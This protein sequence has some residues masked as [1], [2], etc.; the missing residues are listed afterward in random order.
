MRTQSSTERSKTIV[1]ATGFETGAGANAASVAVLD[2]D[3][4]E[5]RLEAGYNMIE[6]AGRG[7][8]AVQ[9]ALR[10]AGGQG[11]ITG[12]VDAIFKRDELSQRWLG[13]Y[14]VLGPDSRI[15]ALESFLSGE[16]YWIYATEPVTWRVPKADEEG[17]G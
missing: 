5:I 13:Y 6:W 2:N 17:D 10:G 3:S 7:G 1:E 4:V 14:P 8:I 16:T 15:N 12:R 11:D 9:E